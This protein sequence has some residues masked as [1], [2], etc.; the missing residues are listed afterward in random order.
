MK[1]F[2]IVRYLRR[3]K[4]LVFALAVA[5]ALLVFFYALKKQTYT[6][7]MTIRFTEG[8]VPEDLREI[9]SPN[10]IDAALVELDMDSDIDRIRSRFRVEPVVPEME[11][12]MIDALLAKG[13]E[14]E[15]ET[16]TYEVIYTDSSKENARDILDAVVKNYYESYTEKLAKEQIPENSVTGLLESGNDY[17]ESAE[18]LEDALSEMLTFISRKENKQRDQRSIHTGFNYEDLYDAFEYMYRH[19]LPLLYVEIVSTAKA[20]DIEVVRTTLRKEIGDLYRHLGHLEQ[21]IDLLNT[22]MVNFTEQT[23]EIDTYHRDPEEGKEAGDNALEGVQ[24]VTGNNRKKTTYDDLMTQYVSLR[25][26]YEQTKIDIDHKEFLLSAFNSKDGVDMSVAL[27]EDPAEEFIRHSDEEETVA[28]IMAEKEL[29]QA[30]ESE[31]AGS[32]ET[33]SSEAGSEGAGS[34]EAASSEAGSE[35]TES[36]GAG[37]AE[38]GSVEVLPED[39]ESANAIVTSDQNGEKPDQTVTDQTAE[40]A[41]APKMHIPFRAVTAEQIEA[42]IEDMVNAYNNYYDI[43]DR[44]CREL[45]VVLS[46]QYLSTVSSIS[47]KASIQLARYVLMSMFLFMVLGLILS[48]LLGRGMELMEGML[49]IDKQ[50]EL[51]N[52]ARCDLY[53][54]ERSESLLPESFCCIVFSIPINQISDRFGRQAGDEVLRDFAHILRSFQEVYGFI[55]YNGGGQFFAFFENCSRRRLKAIMDTLREEVKQYGQAKGNDMMIYR[56]G[57]AI[58]SEDGVYQIRPLLRLAVQRHLQNGSPEAA[59]ATTSEASSAAASETTPAATADAT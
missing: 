8:S 46:A 50:V 47:T 7:S 19:D 6:A 52:R 25:T 5:G 55:A 37:S 1:Q 20:K 30:A 21:Q 38:A 34:A 41:V 26:E 9:Y 24:Q 3:F 31:E 33:A 16:D 4:W 29:L 10:I 18:V 22:L 13:M 53:I 15:Y 42:H 32:E 28:G 11:Q 17:L 59:P 2:S 35:E 54:E 27:P 23:A 56:V 39:L 12:V 14:P 58:T 48:V 43:A 51:P 57:S 45:N 44:T 49:Y 40:T 36:A